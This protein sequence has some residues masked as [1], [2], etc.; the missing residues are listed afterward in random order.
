M[1]TI[2]E[3]FRKFKSRLEL[4]EKEQKNAASR[5]QEIRD[6]M[7]QKF[8]LADDFLTGSYRRHTKTKPLKDVDIFCVL[9]SKESRYRREHPTKVLGAFQHALVDK[10]G[11]KAVT[12]QRRSVSVDFG[13][14]VDVED[15]TDYRVV[16]MDIVPAFAYREDYEIPDSRDSNWIRT[17]PKIHEEK[18]ID[19]HEAYDREWKGLVRMMKYW[20][21]HN[22]KPIKP[23][24][25]IEVMAFECLAPPFSGRFDYEFQSMFATFADRIFDSWEDP[26]QLGPPVSDM[27]DDQKKTAARTALLQA[28]RQSTLAIDLARQGRNGDALKVWRTLFGPKFPLS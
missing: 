9:S 18:A 4:N 13:V 10:Y 24:F 19:A 16:S 20:N 7:R 12:Q 11:D 27:L 25:L 14:V 21:N 17:N 5:H 8:D 28:G 2:E 26:A 23:S 1:L 3:A 6:H 15:N 22:E